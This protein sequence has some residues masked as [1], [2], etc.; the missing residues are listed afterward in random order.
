MHLCCKKLF[1][2]Y[3]LKTIVIYCYT[4]CIPYINGLFLHIF[5]TK[6][7]IMKKLLLTLLIGFT[8]TSLVQAM[9][10]D[11]L[12][13]GIGFE[14]YVNGEWRSRSTSVCVPV[15]SSLLHAVNQFLKTLP[16]LDKNR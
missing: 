3:L 12:W 10:Y 2:I 8:S 4:T 7:S 1:R 5:Y 9:D 11:E 13:I 6:D 14:G 16:G 15:G